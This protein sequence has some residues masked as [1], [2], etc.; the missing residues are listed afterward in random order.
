MRYAIVTETYP[1]EINGV[2]LTVARWIDGLQR[3][4]HLVQLIRAHQ[5]AN[6]E[7][8]LDNSLDTLRLPGFKIP[9]YPQ[10]AGHSCRRL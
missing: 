8:E 6:D 3:R 4:G 9:G 10:Y 5:D 7:R 2:A 1:P